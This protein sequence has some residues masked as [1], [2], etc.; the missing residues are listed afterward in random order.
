M[1]IILSILLVL[2]V[3]YFFEVILGSASSVHDPEI[4]LAPRPFRGERITTGEF[5]KKVVPLVLLS[6]GLPL[7]P[8]SFF[9]GIGFLA[10]S[11]LLF[12]WYPG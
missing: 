12:L 9:L 6:V 7:I 5:F 2:A 1:I 11:L 4:G 10:A 3:L 8:T